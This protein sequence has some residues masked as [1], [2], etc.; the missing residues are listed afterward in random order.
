MGLLTALAL[1]TPIFGFALAPPGLSGLPHR[2]LPVAA[3]LESA[4]EDE[5]GAVDL[6]AQGAARS[7]DDASSAE[8]SGP[9]SSDKPAD[10]ADYVTQLRKRAK[11]AKVHRT[12]G[13]ATW[14]A[15]AIAVAAGTI[16]FRNLY[17]GG[18]RDKTPCVT[19]DAWPNQDQ[20]YGA[21]LLHAIPGF[22]AGGLYFTTMSLAIAMPDPDKADQGDSKFAKTVRTH[23]ILRWIHLVGMLAQ[24]GIGVVMANPKLALNRTDDYDTLQTLARTHLGVGYATFAAL[25]WA[26]TI[27][28]L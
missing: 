14:A 26:G 3:Q 10:Q 15:T 11:I 7:D 17:G 25:T 22:V 12:L 2:V 4:S 5:E 23:K 24:I 20:C 1:A 19:G 6:S 9:T 18:K 28:L 16:Q 27:M 13:I 8:A 21:P